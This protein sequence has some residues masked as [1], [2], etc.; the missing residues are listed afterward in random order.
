MTIS[1]APSRLTTNQSKAKIVPARIQDQLSHA[2]MKGQVHSSR[3]RL[4]SVYNVSSPQPS[5][6]SAQEIRYLLGS[7]NQ[8][9]LHSPLHRDYSIA[10]AE[11]KFL[12]SLLNSQFRYYEQGG[13]PIG[14]ANW[15]WLTDETEEK[16]QQENYLLDQTDWGD[17]K[18]LWF[19]ELIAPFGHL[20]SILKDL[21]QNVFPEESMAKAIRAKQGSARRHIAIFRRRKIF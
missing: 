10:L 7:I 16:I 11:R 15:A 12:P 18:N 8:L 6:L 1:P 13:Q 2:G 9:M 17:G 3:E 19:P 21:Q 14:F 5:R 4:G 20:R